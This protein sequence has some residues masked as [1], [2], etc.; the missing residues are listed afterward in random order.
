MVWESWSLSIR[1]HTITPRH[2]NSFFRFS[3]KISFWML[4]TWADLSG[5]QVKACTKAYWWLLPME[6]MRNVTMAFSSPVNQWEWPWYFT[7]NRYAEFHHLLNY[8]QIWSVCHL[9][10]NLWQAAL[11]LLWWTFHIFQT[12]A[13]AVPRMWVQ[14][15]LY[16]L[17]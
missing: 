6:L 12:V 16:W 10:Q 15:W 4:S 14:K 13:S 8:S 5:L 7:F 2:Y 9:P 3:Y 17:L 1:M 11:V